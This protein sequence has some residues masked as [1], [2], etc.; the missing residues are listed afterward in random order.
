MAAAGA[1]GT[2]ANVAAVTVLKQSAWFRDLGDDLIGAIAALSVQRKFRAGQ[3]IFNRDQVGDTL[4][5]IV[6]GQVRI[7]TESEDGRELALHVAGAGAIGGEIAFLDG[8]GRTA[9]WT[10][11]EDTV[12]FAI[13]RAGFIRL[14]LA[15]PSIALHM[16]S[17]L[18]ERVRWTSQQVE[19]AAF[20]G[21]EQRLARRLAA[22][23]DA[24]QTRAS[25]PEEPIKIRIAQ[26]E[27]A[28]F[29]NVSRQV[30]NGYL[31]EWQRESYV[32]V[33]RGSVTLLDLA[34]LAG[35]AS[36]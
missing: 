34:A 5:G 17:L 15:E 29:L 32:K 9:S 27:L 16:I 6:S 33:G 18:C 14:M 19:E 36:R 3:V 28:N 12:T 21:V 1:S 26:A 31:R 10:A 11:V 8:G 7:T 23:A 20:L 22:L 2:S 35:K 24:T 25:A 13:E 30:V 4:Y